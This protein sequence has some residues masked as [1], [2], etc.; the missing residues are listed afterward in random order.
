MCDNFTKLFSGNIFSAALNKASVISLDFVKLWTVFRDW[1][2][3]KTT[4]ATI[5]DNTNYHITN[6]IGPMVVWG[7]GGV[8][9]H[10]I[11][12]VQGGR[13]RRDDSVPVRVPVY[14]VRRRWRGRAIP[15]RRRRWLV[16]M[17]VA[18]MVIL[19]MVTATAVVVLE[20]RGV[21]VI[22]RRGGG[23]PSR[24]DVHR[25]RGQR[26]RHAAVRAVHRAQRT[27]PVLGR[28]ALPCG[29]G[30]G[31]APRLVVDVLV[32]LHDSS[33]GGGGARS[34]DGGRLRR[35]YT[36]I[37]TT[38]AAADPLTRLRHRRQLATVTR[39][40]STYARTEVLFFPPIRANP[41]TTTTHRTTTR[42]F[43][44]R[45][46]SSPPSAGYAVTTES[47]DERVK[48]IRVK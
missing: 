30:R 19:V 31:G 44:P 23:R 1:V 48:V 20:V 36:I 27:R 12:L 9:G 10:G 43:A 38:A 13:Q 40:R 25:R 32:E 15:N 6:M 28:R 34:T 47:F 5:I 7:F 4:T 45:P 39:A 21:V 26:R 2:L 33:G 42:P 14:R 29:G 17:A 3:L 11:S 16:I 22:R 35:S 8:I 37:A 24:H 46:T 18:Q 41:P